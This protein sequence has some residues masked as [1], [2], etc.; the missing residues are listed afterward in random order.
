MRRMDSK[1]GSTR[2][3]AQHIGR[4]AVTG[5]GFGGAEQREPFLLADIQYMYMS[6]RAHEIERLMTF[7]FS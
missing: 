4:T 5:R 2:D 6:I 7:C 1:V 3:M